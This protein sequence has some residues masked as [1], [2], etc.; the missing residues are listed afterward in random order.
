MSDFPKVCINKRL[1]DDEREK[2][3]EKAIEE[4]PANSPFHALKFLNITN[5]EPITPQVVGE[6]LKFWSPGRTLKIKF[7][8]GHPEIQQKV[9]EHAMEWTKHANIHF[10]F[11][12]DGNAEIRISFKHKGSWSYVGTDCLNPNLSQNDATM[13]YGWFTLDTKDE[14]YSR[15]V[16]HEFGHALGLHHEQMR[17]DSGIPW[18]KEAVYQDYMKCDIRNVDPCWT[19]EEVDQNVFELLDLTLMNYSRYDKDSIMQYPIPDR[20]TIGDFEIGFNR[21]LSPLDKEF[22]GKFYP[23]N[24]A[25]VAKMDFLNI[26]T[27]SEK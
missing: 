12:Q 5:N 6:K 17:P 18:D 10:D 15:T 20:H 22:I 4:N 8:D 14:E 27:T 1:R 7:L 24:P 19:K 23:F 16:L 11:I 2:T 26:A 21:Q 3:M 9:K 13:N 25:T